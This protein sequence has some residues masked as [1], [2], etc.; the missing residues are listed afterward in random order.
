PLCQN[1]TTPTALPTS[2]NNATP[3][4]GTW[5]PAFS[6]ATVGTTT[7][8]FTPDAGQCATTAT[9]DVVITTQI[10]P[11]FTQVGPLCQN[12][13]TP[14]AL[15][16]SS[17]NATPI[18]GT[19]SPA[20]STATV[21]T[22]TY[23]FTPDAGQCATTATMDVVI[24]TQITPTFTQVGPLC[25]NATTP[26]ALPTSSNNT[27]PI[28]GVWSPAFSTA[29]VGTTTYTFTPDAGQCATTATMDV[30]I[31]APVVPTFT[32][33]GP[34][35]QNATTPTALPTSS[36]N[37]TPITGTWSPAFSTAT[38][39]TTTYTFTPDAGQCATTATM[40]VVITAPVVPTFTQVGP[41]CQNATTPTALPTSSNNATPI[42]GTWSPAFST[43][44]VGT[45]TYTFTPDAGQ[46]ATTAT[47]DVVI[48]A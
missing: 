31:T 32:Q 6:T 27:T 41:L 16:T 44:T 35:C 1:A 15:P 30:V 21:G 13:T 9:M 38:V 37:A 48:T 33:V 3:I 10:T 23:T 42:T 43:A 29:T 25:Q 46:C 36:N 20:F 24:T 7:Y 2:S 34:L 22:T 26:T 19:W 17:N 4:T 28:T 45:T 5:S 47:M 8:T 40:D 39:G 12:A 14:T 11:T 18:T